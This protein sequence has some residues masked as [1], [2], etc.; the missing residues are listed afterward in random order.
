MKLNKIFTVA[1][2][3]LG[4]TLFQSCL[5]DQEDF[6]EDSPSERMQS[7]LDKARKV[8]T[9][10]PEGWVFEYFPGKN[11][12]YGG[13]VYTIKFD[14]EKATVGCEI[15]PGY[16][17]SSYYKFTNDN[18]PI[19][20]F[21][22]YNYLIHYFAEPSSGRY[23]GLDGDYEFI[24][25]DIT[26]DLVTLK[27]KRTG[28]FMFLRRL[29]SSAEEYIN[30]VSEMSDNLFLTAARGTLNGEPIEMECD[31]NDRTMTLAWGELLASKDEGMTFDDIIKNFTDEE[32]TKNI[33]ISYFLPTPTGVSFPEPIEINGVTYT[34]LNFDAESLTFTGE[35]LSLT[36]EVP[37]EYTFLKEFD[38]AFSF[39]YNGGS[40][41]IDVTLV[42]NKSAKTVAIKGLNPNY[43]VIATY[44]P[45]NGRI[46]I[47]SQIVYNKVDGS[48]NLWL[49]GW[50]SPESGSLNRSTD[51]GM[52]C[53]KDVN[54]PGTYIFKTN[55]SA[56]LKAYS[57]I[58][59]KWDQSGASQGE[60]SG[61]T[62]Y[63]IGGSTRIPSLV[64]LVKK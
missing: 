37:A 18:G 64:S 26:D 44:D 19:L 48:N 21:D 57:F 62:A 54:N 28:N 56:T 22:T 9:S 50:N 7:T 5:K 35:G 52:F 2:I 34:G 53:Y 10:S 49:T 55:N 41:S 38:G 8:L 23:Q 58:L 63:Y 17:E 43:D 60:A 13:Y 31:L 61:L 14:D 1:L 47:N 30:A 25:M 33:A 51:V 20:A 16:T 4:T 40:K 39:V 27:G 46:E 45:A 12:Q 6:F 36:G 59:W 32:I 24:I 42:P 15:D 3:A 29:N 11:Y